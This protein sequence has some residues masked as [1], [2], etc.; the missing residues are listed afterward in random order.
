M[1]NR[2]LNAE[3]MRDKNFATLLEQHAKEIIKHLIKRGI[4]FS[5]LC[6]VPKLSFNPML[7]VLE[8]LQPFSVF[9]LA[10][11]TFESIE[12]GE[13]SLQF[14]AGFGK[15]NE[16]SFVQVPF[17]AIVQISLC[18]DTNLQ[19]NVIFT[20]IFAT[21]D[22]TANKGIADSMRAFLQNPENQHLKQ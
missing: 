8:H 4:I 5:I 9:V 14:E 15:D 19:E 1:N 7:D 10:G 11:Y 13:D 16:G 12:V 21:L 17:S 18:S 20:N 22:D 2:I 6:N 3:L